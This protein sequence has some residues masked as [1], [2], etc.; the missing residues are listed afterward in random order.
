MLHIPVVR[1][2]V[3]SANG[4]QISST[5]AL[6]YHAYLYYLQRLGMVTGFMQISALYDIRRGAGNEVDG[7]DSIFLRELVSANFDVEVATEALPQ[8]VMNHRQ[9]FSSLPE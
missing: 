7:V 9:H 3:P 8:Q 1:Q 2:A 4:V 5:K 6:P